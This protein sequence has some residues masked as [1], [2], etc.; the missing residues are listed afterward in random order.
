[1]ARVAIKPQ[2]DIENIR[3]IGELHRLMSMVFGG[4]EFAHSELMHFFD[5]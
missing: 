3:L 1:M 2:R 5:V 4:D